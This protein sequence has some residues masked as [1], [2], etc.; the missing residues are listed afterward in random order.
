VTHQNNRK[1]NQF[2]NQLNPIKHGKE[3]GKTNVFPS[4]PPEWSS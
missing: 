4:M 3:E 1:K 2:E